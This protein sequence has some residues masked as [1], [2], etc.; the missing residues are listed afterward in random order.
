MIDTPDLP[1]TSDTPDTP[2]NKKILIGDMNSDGNITAA[3]ALLILRKSVSAITMS[4][5]DI[6]IADTNRDG[7]ITASDALLI[8][9]YAVNAGGNG[10]IGT[11]VEVSIVI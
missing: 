11:W 4:E 7:R 6:I 3:D 5:N 9:R 8:L 10:Y 2:D 1:D